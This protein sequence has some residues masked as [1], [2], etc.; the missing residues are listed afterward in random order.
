MKRTFTV[1]LTSIFVLTLVFGGSAVSARTIYKNT[2]SLLGVRANVSGDGYSWNNY[3]NIL[4]L[5]GI[6]IETDDD[7]GLKILDGATVILKGTNYIK[8]SKAAVFIEGKVIIKG[9]GTLVLEG[10]NGIYCSSNDSTDR[11]T[12]NG[13]KYE[14]TSRSNGIVS[15]FHSVSITN[16]KVNISSKGGTAIKAKWLTVGAKTA[17]TA[18]SPL[19]GQDKLHIEGAN[20]TLECDSSALVSGNTITFSKLDLKTGSSASSLSAADSYASEAFVKTT[21]TYDDSR[22]SL[23]L[24]SGYSAAF[25]ILILAS[26]ILVLSCAVVLPIVIKKRKAYAAIDTRDKAEAERIAEARAKKKAA[27]KSDE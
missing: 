21:S 7:Y 8:A 24:G 27:K 18:D 5:D 11:L 23:L 10:E 20:V 26:V 2:I 17:L 14:I 19:V 4:T 16:S 6:T 15:D 25:D 12:I 22:K 9:S 3:D 13:G 1:L